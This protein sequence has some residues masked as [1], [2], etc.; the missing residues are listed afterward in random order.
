MPNRE[1][2]TLYEVITCSTRLWKNGL[3]GLI[4]MSDT[5]I[6][7]GQPRIVLIWV[8]GSLLEKDII[9]QYAVVGASPANVFPQIFYQI[10]PNFRGFPFGMIMVCCFIS[11]ADISTLIMFLQRLPTM[12]GA[13]VHTT[14]MEK[15]LESARWPPFEPILSGC[16]Y[17]KLRWTTTCGSGEAFP[18]DL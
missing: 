1:I 8:W 14:V 2:F 10:M 3:I 9:H 17:G 12:P 4:S 13:K 15:F 6:A 7:K 5:T 18:L 16:L 11:A